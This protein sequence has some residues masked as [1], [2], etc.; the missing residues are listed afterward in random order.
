MTNTDFFA[1]I[2]D[3][4]IKLRK[5]LME[6]KQPIE[7]PN[8]F[9]KQ[10]ENRKNNNKLIFMNPDEE[11]E[12]SLKQY[13]KD[14]ENLKN[15]FKKFLTRKNEPSKERRK[16]Y[17]ID[18]D[19]RYENA[20]DLQNFKRIL[21]GKG[22]WEKIKIPHYHGPTGKWVSYY[23]T[24]FDY[25]KKDNSAFLVFKGSDYITDVYLNG[26]HVLNHEGFFYSF[27]QDIT[28]YLLEKDNVLVVK[29][30]NDIT[31]LGEN[32]KYG[33]KIYAATGIGWDDPLDGWHHCPPGGGIF[34]KVYIEQRE[35]IHTVDACVFPDIDNNF[36]K[37]KII[38]KSL[39]FEN[40][41]ADV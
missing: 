4:K 31:T 19:F 3:T 36:A 9:F 18:F 10:T 39:S 12:E 11:Y 27:E 6:S 7:A 22:D 30:E 35:V 38:V 23:R 26:R 33:K 28:Q 2:A 13:S 20:E 24:I 37:V 14:I 29:V 41:K 15:H 34:D 32:R 5:E 16:K 8:I 25:D 17:L 21:E 1:A 40:T